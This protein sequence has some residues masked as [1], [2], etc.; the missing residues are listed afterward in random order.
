MR[1]V[2]AL[3]NLILIKKMRPIVITA[4][5]KRTTVKE[6]DEKKTA[7]VRILQRETLM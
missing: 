6:K 4:A 3:W 2:C 7:R 1:M 5:Q